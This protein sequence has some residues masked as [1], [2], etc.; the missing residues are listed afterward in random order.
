[1]NILRT[2]LLTPLP[3]PNHTRSQQEA[4]TQEEAGSGPSPAA[5]RASS[6]AGQRQHGSSSVQGRG[7]DSGAQRGGQ[8]GGEGEDH[9]VQRFTGHR[10]VQTVK[11]RGVS[12]YSPVVH[13]VYQS[14]PQRLRVSSARNT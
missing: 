3:I 4:G 8:G 9:C 10:N 2:P 1:M 5:Q 13:T 12:V 7:W 14:H 11:V 6:A